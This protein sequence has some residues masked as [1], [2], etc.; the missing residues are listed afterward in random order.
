ME[1]CFKRKCDQHTIFYIL[2]PLLVLIFQLQVKA[3]DSLTSPEFK[4]HGKP[5]I[6]VFGNFDY[7]ATK[8]AD[9]QYRF[10]IGRAYLG[11]EYNYS[12]QFSGKIVID[13]GRPTTVGEIVVTDSLGN[14]L[15]VSNS[16]NEGSYYTM[17]LKFASLQW[18]PDEHFKIQVGAVLQNHFITQ[19]KFWGYR[20]L[21]ET[22]Q[23]RYF[24]IPSSDLGLIAYYSPN[25]YFSLDFA[26]TNGEG[27]RFDQDAYG[28]VKLAAG[29]DIIPVKGLQTRFYTDFTSSDDPEKPYSQQLFSVFAGYKFRAK[30]RIGGEFNYRKNHQFKGNHDLFGGSVYGSYCFRKNLEVFV[31][32]DDLSAN[33]LDG[34]AH[35]WYY[36]NTGKALITGI[37]FCP[38][39]KINLSLNYQG[40]IPDN[41]DINHQHHILFS[42]EYNL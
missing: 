4:P 34:G 31:R 18:K 33:Y 25:K 2:L 26:L 28:D 12:R 39:E 27:F 6:T 11:Y 9:K 3:G 38:V 16:S 42:F 37:H 17:S 13:V 20:Y 35:N 21:A 29:I 1:A 30:F 36:D 41:T 32:Y 24:K 15:N 22:F 40:W 10:W 23:D 19:E 8:D 5:I 7:N 14:E